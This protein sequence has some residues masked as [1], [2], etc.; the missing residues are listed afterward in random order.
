MNKTNIQN[1]KNCG[2]S[3]FNKGNL[4]EK[5]IYMWCSEWKPLKLCNCKSSETNLSKP[6]FCLKC[7]KKI[8]ET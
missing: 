2:S 5:V 3:R 7:N 1:C 8:K 6:F 4:C